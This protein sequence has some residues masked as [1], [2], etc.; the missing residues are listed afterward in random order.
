MGGRIVGPGS[1]VIT[2]GIDLREKPTQHVAR[3][4]NYSPE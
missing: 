4:G 1:Q 3:V 2:G